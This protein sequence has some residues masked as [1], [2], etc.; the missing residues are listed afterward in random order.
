[1]TS[2]GGSL[3]HLFSSQTQ[4]VIS[5]DY[6]SRHGGGMPYADGVFKETIARGADYFIPIALRIECEN[7]AA[8]I[9]IKSIQLITESGN[10]ILQIPFQLFEALAILK[11]TGNVKVYRFNFR[12]F[13]QPIPV[14]GAELEVFAIQAAAESTANIRRLNFL[15]EYKYI[16]S[17]ERIRLT[18]APASIPRQVFQSRTFANPSNNLHICLLLNGFQ[19][20]S[21]GYILEGPIDSI[22]KLECYLSSHIRHSYTSD[23]F[24]FVSKRINTNLLYVP[25]DPTAADRVCGDIGLDTHFGFNGCLDYDRIDSVKLHL[26]TN[27]P[28]ASFTVHSLSY[29]KIEI[30]RQQLRPNVIQFQLEPR[31]ATQVVD[32]PALPPPERRMVPFPPSLV[33]TPIG[34]T[35]LRNL[36]IDEA[37]VVRENVTNHSALNGSR[38]WGRWRREHRPIDPERSH[39]AIE[40]AQIGPGNTY[41]NCT[42]CSNNFTATSLQ[43]YFAHQERHHGDKRCPTCRANWSNWVIYTNAEPSSSS[44][45]SETESDSKDDEDDD[46]VQDDTD[47]DDTDHDEHYEDGEEE[48]NSV[49]TPPPPPRNYSGGSPPNAVRGTTNGRSWAGWSQD[50]LDSL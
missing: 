1:M 31:D 45:E 13:M 30:E 23:M 21:K 2:V 11:V 47:Q 19:G 44:A 42:D 35:I 6:N 26:E 10:I 29:S 15:C 33:N 37:G 40:Q 5:V 16:G 38:R 39:C 3:I 8:P 27:A 17:A 12:G 25:F 28:A 18:E 20:N 24:E 34:T 32:S 22:T 14:V 48:N 50:E 49:E 43:N 9:N 41:C 36:Q 7:I 46:T 4:S